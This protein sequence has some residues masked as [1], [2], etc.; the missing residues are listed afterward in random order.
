M[1]E[2]TAFIVGQSLV[3]DEDFVGGS[4]IVDGGIEAAGTGAVDVDAFT[5]SPAGLIEAMVSGPPSPGFRTGNSVAGGGG[6]LRFSRQVA[7]G[8]ALRSWRTV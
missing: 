5:D 6:A 8:H 2:G 3:G 7:Q 4:E 1:A